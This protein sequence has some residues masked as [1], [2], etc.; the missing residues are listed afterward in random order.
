MTRFVKF[1]L[2]RPR[3]PQVL[4]ELVLLQ[5]SS[6]Q[7]AQKLLEVSFESDDVLGGDMIVV[8]RLVLF[9][10]VSEILLDELGETVGRKLKIPI[11]FREL[12]HLEQ[13]GESLPGLVKS[14]VVDIAHCE[15]YV[16]VV[17]EGC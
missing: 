5:S 4:P 7:Q 17:I 3:V 13:V 14:V 6:H 10:R 15:Q 1:V 16:W 12:A 2:L 9:F 8:N 11:F